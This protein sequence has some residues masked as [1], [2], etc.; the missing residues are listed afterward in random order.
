MTIIR[1]DLSDKLIHL[2]NKDSDEEP[3]NVLCKILEQN[4]LIGNIKYRRG[5]KK[6]ICFS[7]AP[8]NKIAQLIINSKNSKNFERRLRYAPFGV[9]VSK[10]WLFEKGGRP[11]IYQT[12]EE[13]DLLPPELQY[14]H[15]IF[16]LKN[17]KDYTWEREWRLKGNKLELDPDNT[18]II[19]PTRKYADM[20]IEKHIETV[21]KQC[22]NDV[23]LEMKTQQLT[24]VQVSHSVFNRSLF[25]YPWHFVV[26]EDLGFSF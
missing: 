17:D 23:K 8:I 13:Y 19:I 9:M 4:K 5:S 16:D 18:T 7:E 3:F 2:V 22:D 10:K 20:L 14:K 1:D 26:L 24:K 12:D 6:S 25:K 15:V 11:V 21:V